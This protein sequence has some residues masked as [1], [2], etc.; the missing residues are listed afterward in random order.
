MSA[1]QSLSTSIVGH[2]GRIHVDFEVDTS[3]VPDPH[4]LV[5]GLQS[6]LEELSALAR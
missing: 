5:D 4:A 3:A 6:E 2:D 1:D